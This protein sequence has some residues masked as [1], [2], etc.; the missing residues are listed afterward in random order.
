MGI[1]SPLDSDAEL[2]AKQDLITPY[3][4]R[5]EFKVGPF[6]YDEVQY[7]KDEGCARLWL[8]ILADGLDSSASEHGA[9]IGLL[10]RSRIL[11]T[12]TDHTWQQLFFTFANCTEIVE[13]FVKFRDPFKQDGEN[14]SEYSEWLFKPRYRTDGKI[15]L[16][17]IADMLSGIKRR[18]LF[19]HKALSIF[20]PHQGDDSAWNHGAA[21][22]FL[23]R[24]PMYIAWMRFEPQSALQRLQ[25]TD[26]HSQ[27]FLPTRLEE[28]EDDMNTNRR[29]AI[30]QAYI[31]KNN[32]LIRGE[33][34]I[35]IAHRVRWKR[36]TV[37]FQLSNFCLLNRQRQHR[38][39]ISS[40]REWGQSYTL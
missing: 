3:L 36:L 2:A 12:S 29:L 21:E 27:L 8:S 19:Q 15:T 11:Y 10:G 5:K 25:R 38:V 14:F 4:K 33:S 26:H 28:L 35:F 20:K 1:A 23:Q 30:C 39:W 22:R 16:G 18:T 40:S 32:E 24:V 17:K 13:I 6:K 37:T 31:D 7:H 34:G 9:S